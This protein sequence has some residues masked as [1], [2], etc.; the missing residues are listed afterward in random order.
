MH[1]YPKRERIWRLTHSG[2]PFEGSETRIENPAKGYRT[3][4]PNAYRELLPS[5]DQLRQIPAAPAAKLLPSAGQSSRN[6]PLAVRDE[7]AVL[8]RVGFRSAICGPA[9]AT[10]TSF[11]T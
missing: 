7:I 8:Y 4:S 6:H 1:R 3:V 9:D 2:D 11:C 5:H 10:T